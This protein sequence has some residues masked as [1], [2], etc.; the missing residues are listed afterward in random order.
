MLLLLSILNPIFLFVSFFFLIRS[1]RKLRGSRL[2]GILLSLGFFILI[3]FVR[4]LLGVARSPEIFDVYVQNLE[5]SFFIDAV[6]YGG[7]FI[8]SLFVLKNYK[9]SFIAL[10][11]K[12][13]VV[14]LLVVAFVMTYSTGYTL[15]YYFEASPYVV[16]SSLSIGMGIFMGI[17]LIPTYFNYFKTRFFL[18]WCR[19]GAALFLLTAVNYLQVVVETRSLG[20]L[21]VIPTECIRT[22]CF[23]LLAIGLF[24]FRRAETQIALPQHKFVA[25]KTWSEKESLEEVFIY[26]EESLISLYGAFYGIKNQH[27]LEKK[28]NSIVEKEGDS[29]RF[30]SGR[31]HQ[32]SNSLDLLEQAQRLRKHFQLT[33]E[34]LIDYCGFVFVHRYLKQ[35]IQ[36]LYWT[37]KDIADTHLFTPLS[38]AKK[39]ISEEKD[40]EIPLEDLLQLNPL[41]HSLS[42]E[43]N[44]FLI[45][46]FKRKTFR[47]GKKIVREGGKGD[48]FYLMAQGECVV[49]KRR[50]WRQVK[51]V[52]LRKGD[53]FG[54]RALL[55]DAKRFATVQA[56]TE[57]VLYML[58]KEDFLSILKVYFDVLPKMKQSYNRVEFLEQVPIFSPFSQIQLLYMA[59]KMV[60]IHYKANETILQQGDSGEDFYVMTEGQA[61]VLIEQGEKGV[62]TIARLEKGECFGE[63]A[64]LKKVE[65]TATV[66]AVTDLSCYKLKQADFNFLFKE[67]YYNK[68]RLEKLILRREEDL[69]KKT[70]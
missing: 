12:C 58:N 70:S 28:W 37:E 61:E 10:W 1:L 3:L 52:Q 62:Q 26:L 16:K 59:S 68:K 46:R 22:F 40:Q 25:K 63:I 41:F 7:L 31:L 15:I 48:A 69:K 34:L 50:N 5:T 66:R 33:Y 49:K 17:L 43:E 20:P 29:I 19:I 54:E 57:V 4:S 2:E 47:K 64:L 32:V 60:E 56:K 65:R 14:S 55:E 21:L 23:W 45:P 30:V 9:R 44:D 39:F 53:T 38:F 51:L 11:E 13:L 27:G 18:P 8:C 67:C 35:L 6:A 42:K 24:T 36:E